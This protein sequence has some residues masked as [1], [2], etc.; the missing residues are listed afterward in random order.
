MKPRFKNTDLE[1]TYKALY[2]Y[3]PEKLQE[4][5]VYGGI[6]SMFTKGYNGEPIP[7][8]L[9]RNC[10]AYAAYIAGKETPKGE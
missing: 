5:K 8:Y 1:I 2:G 7:Y 6:C 3:T 9:S 4:S 10:P